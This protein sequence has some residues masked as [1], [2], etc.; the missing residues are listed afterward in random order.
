M[1]NRSAATAGMPAESKTHHTE[2]SCFRVLPKITAKTQTQ[3]YKREL[4]VNAKGV[5]T[6][7]LSSTPTEFRNGLP[8]MPVATKTT[9]DAAIAG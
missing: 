4:N 8:K 1:P 5:A 6:L 9:I 7:E 2:F 3:T